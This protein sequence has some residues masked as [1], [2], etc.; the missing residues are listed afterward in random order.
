MEYVSLARPSTA[1]IKATVTRPFSK[2][3]PRPTSHRSAA[4]VKPPSHGWFYCNLE[5]ES[6]VTQMRSRP[7]TPSAPRNPPAP[8]HR[9]T[10]HEL[11]LDG[12]GQVDEHEFEAYMSANRM[13]VYGAAHVCIQGMLLHTQDGSHQ[14]KGINGEYQRSDDRTCNGRAVYVKMG[15]PSIAMWWANNEGKVSWCVGPA[16]SIGK[17]S[18]WA[19]VESMGRGPEEAGSRPW[20]VYSYS[21]AAWEEQHDIEVLNLDKDMEDEAGAA[22]VSSFSRVH[23]TTNFTPLRM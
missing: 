10:K 23:R 1:A 6:L 15:K 2:M 11:D 9:E 16:D 4:S 18:M 14:Y 20:Y 7:Q 22:I 17:R 5:E 8:L 19:Y 3:F 12:D 13:V 21:S